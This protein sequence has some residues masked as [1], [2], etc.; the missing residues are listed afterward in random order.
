PMDRAVDGCELPYFSALCQTREGAGSLHDDM[1]RG[2]AIN[3]VELTINSGP[4][5]DS[6]QIAIDML[7]IGVRDPDTDSGETMPAATS[8]A[9]L[10]SA[11][12]SMSS[13]SVDLVA[14]KRIKSIVLSY[15]NNVD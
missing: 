10:K 1:W 15:Q 14:A 13:L 4:G 2:M 9:F 11:S 8:E 5:R 6:S 3:G 12:L 7:G